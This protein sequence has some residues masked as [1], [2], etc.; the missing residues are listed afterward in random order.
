MDAFSDQLESA[1]SNVHD[2][3]LNWY[4][5]NQSTADLEAI[6][7]ALDG[8]MTKVS[9]EQS[10]DFMSLLRSAMR[11]YNSQPIVAKFPIDGSIA[12][13]RAAMATRMEEVKKDKV[14]G[15]LTA[16]HNA[17]IRGLLE[18]IEMLG[19]TL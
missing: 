5:D 3:L 8:I 16:R 10:Q 14:L 18:V 15:G 9:N 12:D 1:F 19:G 13:I 7:T 2:K 6:E 17:N 11:E 4:V